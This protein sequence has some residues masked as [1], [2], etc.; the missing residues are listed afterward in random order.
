MMF[1][2]TKDFNFTLTELE[3]MMPFEFDIYY[4]MILEETKKRF[5]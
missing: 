2:I 5:K 1:Q 4:D 3:N